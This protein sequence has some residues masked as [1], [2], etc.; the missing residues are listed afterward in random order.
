MGQ[1]GFE[2]HVRAWANW[3]IVGSAAIWFWS[4][5]VARG[6]L[7]MTC[8]SVIGAWYFAEFASFFFAF[9]LYLTL[10]CHSPLAPLPPAT[11]THTIHAALVRSTGPSLGSIVLASLILT[12]LRIFMLTALLLRRLPPLLLRIPWVPLSVPI[13]LYIVP[14]VEWLVRLLEMKS[15]TLSRYALVYGGLTG[16]GFWESAVRGREL[17]SGVEGPIVGH[18]DDEPEQDQGR[19]QGRRAK[20]AKRGQ[21]GNQPTP[22]QKKRKFGSERMYT[23]YLCFLPCIY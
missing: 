7:R 8:A 17:V 22:N 10:H 14:G 18:E 12:L 4:W 1:S 2:W 11:S 20:R 13:A 19:Q 9:L 21:R 3:A 23:I 6:V 16:A 15:G 5:A